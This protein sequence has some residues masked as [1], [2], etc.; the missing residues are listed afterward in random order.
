MQSLEKKNVLVT[1]GAGFIGSHLCEK[2][3]KTSRIICLD[4]F[5]T[6]N[7]SN[8]DFLLQHPDFVFIK[9]DICEPVDLE[10]LP[11]LDRFKIKFQGVQEIYHLACPTSAKSFDKFKAATLEAN[12]V[13]MKN[14]LDLAVKYKA[15]VVHASSSVIYGPR[16]E[17]EEFFKE[18][19]LGCVNH[20][21]PR[22]SYDEGKRFAETMIETY[23]EMHGLDAKIARIFRTYGPRERLFDG[24]MVPDF[25]IDALDNKD[26]IIYGDENFSTSLCYVDDVVSGLI[27]LMGAPSDIGPV[28]IGSNEDLKL[29]DVAN[30][31]ISMTGSESKIVFEKPLLFMS[32]L[33]LPDTSRAKEMLGWVPL[34]RLEDGLQKAIDYTQAY[35]PLLRQQ[36]LVD[37]R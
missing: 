5:S 33:G 27:K 13:G 35:K 2:L 16:Q 26:L 31:I 24:E 22:G 11:E 23:R 4:N 15:K 29:F 18:D 37:E 10:T 21:T 3:I 32:P 20:L 7:V 9:H 6:S 25:I 8:I 17:N 30:K 36:G 34:V 12:S 28:N 14:I 19:A 1:G